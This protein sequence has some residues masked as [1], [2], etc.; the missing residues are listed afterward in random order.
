M[1]MGAST[2]ALQRVISR[3]NLVSAVLPRE[4][5]YALADGPYVE[6]IYP[7]EV[8]YA[9][10]YPQVG[11][12]GAFSSP[13]K[14]TGQIAFTSTYWTKKLVGADLAN[15][16]GY[17][18]KGVKV[19]VVDSGASRIHE[20]IRR[21]QF[22]TVMQEYRDENGHGTWCTSCIGGVQAKDEYLSQ[23]SQRDVVCEGMAPE[24]DLLAV[25]SLGYFVGAGSTSD[26]IAAIELSLLRGADI[27]NLSLGYEATK[28]LSAQDDPYYAVFQKVLEHNIIPVVAAG[29][30]GAKIQT[31][32]SPGSMPNVLTVGA[33]NPI[34]GGIA[35]YSSRGPTLWNEIK[36]D[37]VA[38]GTYIDGAAVGVLDTAGDGV[39]SRFS[40]LSGTS[41]A[42]PHV[43]GL[44]A[45]MRECMRATVGKTLTVDEVKL[46]MQA[47]GHEK[48]N[49][50]GFGFIHWKIFEQWMDTQYGVKI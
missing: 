47:L 1:M 25:K 17:R 32:N 46:M 5:I 38:P 31:I 34:K 41:M 19:S 49:T 18:G 13:Y 23:R 16:K 43:S 35:P 33:F 15:G 10:Q 29:N 42:T 50:D 12:E 2:W 9:F 20:M 27:I 21:V 7:D 36:P 4:A 28:I 8:N 24:C 22:E 48:N 26:C 40:P 39:P 3:F 14:G 44:L 30:S 6:K 11:A 37:V 45:L